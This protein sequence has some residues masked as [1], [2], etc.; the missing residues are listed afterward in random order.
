MFSVVWC[1]DA[2]LGRLSVGCDVCELFMNVHAYTHP[3]V[4]F[5]CSASLCSPSLCS[6]SLC[7][8]FLCSRD[9]TVTVPVALALTLLLSLCSQDHTV[10]GR[11]VSG[12]SHMARYEDA[13]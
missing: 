7:S 5:L 4:P 3:A 2:V 10:G 9:R 8:P 13:S 12:L 1:G 6:P 11:A